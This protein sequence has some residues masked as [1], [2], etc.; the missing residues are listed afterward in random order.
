MSVESA[1]SDVALSLGVPVDSLR[2]LIQF[3]SRFD[4]MAKNP[5]TG[6]SGLIQFIDSTARSLGYGSATELVLQH[7]DI[8]SQLRGPVLKYLSQFKPFK[9][10]QSLYLSVF[11]PSYR[12]SPLTTEFP[13]SVKAVNPGIRYVGDYVAKVEKKSFKKYS[14]LGFVLPIAA[15]TL[16]V[17][18]KQ[19]KRSV[20]NVKGKGI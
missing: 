17:F 20:L 8:E 1:L 10:P 4:P 2:K 12:F 14:F 5:Y 16:A 19:L 6:A 7:P 3:E 9:N 15:I 13:D 18:F 11:Y